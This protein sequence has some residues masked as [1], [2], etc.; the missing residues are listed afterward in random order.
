MVCL[1]GLE[2]AAA[3]AGG[4][5]AGGRV[6]VTHGGVSLFVAFFVLVP[7]AQSLLLAARI[8][9]RLMPAAITLGTLTFTMSALPGHAGHSECDADAF[10]RYHAFRG[11]WTG[12]YCIPCHAWFRDVVAAARSGRGTRRW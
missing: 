6:V 8:P 7:M 4:S 9:R 5:A 11:S 10:L 12:H 3:G 1:S 2:R